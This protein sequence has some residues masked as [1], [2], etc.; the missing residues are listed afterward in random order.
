MF[1]RKTIYKAILISL[2]A[3]S[4]ISALV[5]SEKQGEEG[6]LEQSLSSAVLG[7]GL[8]AALGA[9]QE[10]KELMSVVK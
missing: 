5:A 1:Q 10:L 9:L 3:A 4:V 6:S 2:I 8:V 7:V